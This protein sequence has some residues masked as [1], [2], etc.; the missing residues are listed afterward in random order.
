VSAP[1]TR[2]PFVSTKC[3][4]TGSHKLTALAILRLPSRT[5][6]DGFRQVHS[7]DA[8]RWCAL[9]WGCALPPRSIHAFTHS[10]AG[11]LPLHTWHTLFSKV[12]QRW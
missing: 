12:G 9:A 8:R 6:L 11:P 5:I 7:L 10:D 3:Y 4:A 2:A 1:S